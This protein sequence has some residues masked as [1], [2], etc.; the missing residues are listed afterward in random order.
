M[1]TVQFAP[2]IRVPVSESPAIPMQY[3]VTAYLLRDG[4]CEGAIAC[5]R[6]S[7]RQAKALLAFWLRR[8]GPEHFMGT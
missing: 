7:K 3:E 5:T 6:R 2:A 8:S 1:I 4:V